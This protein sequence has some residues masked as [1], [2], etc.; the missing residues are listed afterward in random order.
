MNAIPGNQRLF[1][2]LGVLAAF[3]I[4]AV[5]V[6]VMLSSNRPP[7]LDQSRIAERKA[8]LAEIRQANAQAL[9]QND[10]LDQSKGIVRLN[11][12]NAMELTLKEYQNPE[13][14]RSNLVARAEKAL[15]VPPAPPP[16]P[17]KYE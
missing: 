5:L 8:A 11:I 13:A 9:S 1:S 16:A 4:V 14:A 10:W 3:L 6:G 15:A 12:T 7:P 2:A 17:N